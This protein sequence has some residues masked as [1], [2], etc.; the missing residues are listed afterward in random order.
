MQSPLIL[1]S[2]GLAAREPGLEINRRTWTA[3]IVVTTHGSSARAA[4]S[5]VIAPGAVA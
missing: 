5:G 3:N 1:G 4:I 2:T